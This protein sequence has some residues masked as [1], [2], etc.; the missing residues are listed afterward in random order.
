MGNRILDCCNIDNKFNRA[1]VRIIFC[2]RNSRKLFKV[3]DNFLV[4]RKCCLEST[5]VSTSCKCA[6]NCP[7]IDAV[8]CTC[9][10][11]EVNNC[12]LWEGCYV[13]I[14]KCDINAVTHCRKSACFIEF[15]A[16]CTEQ[17]SLECEFTLCWSNAYYCECH[18]AFD[19]LKR[20]ALCGIRVVSTIKLPMIYHHIVRN[21]DFD[22]EIVVNKCFD[23]KLIFSL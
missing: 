2:Y 10:C 1:I 12:A 9:S 17:F 3:N 15:A 20:N 21:L 13:I 18:I 5:D 23:S 16:V 19:I 4:C 7:L 8:A 14:V 6:V 11:C 22:I